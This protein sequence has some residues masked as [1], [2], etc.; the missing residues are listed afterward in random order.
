MANSEEPKTNL[1]PMPSREEQLLAADVISR[2]HWGPDRPIIPELFEAHCS[3]FTTSCEL[4]V[5]RRDPGDLS[6]FQVLLIR[7][8][9]DDKSYAGK[10]HCAGSVRRG[11]EPD[12][13]VLARIVRQELPG[14][15][16]STPRF[17]CHNDVCP[18]RG[19]EISALY[20]A[21]LS[22]EY[23]GPGEWFPIHELPEDT[24]GHHRMLAHQVMEW[25]KHRTYASDWPDARTVW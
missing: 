1:P 19:K 4:M 3:A 12:E 5:V 23:I 11:H 17:I 9:S 18:A 24:L 22:G 16:L 14:A 21:K 8:P 25:L 6:R 2:L 15:E 7:R 13:D 10:Y 20:V